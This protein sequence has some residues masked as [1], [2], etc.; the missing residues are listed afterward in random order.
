M[1]YLAHACSILMEYPKN[2]P[3]AT[4]LA[5]S[6]YPNS[7]RASF[8]T[9][10]A[11]PGYQTRQ[12]FTQICIWGPAS[13][14]TAIANGQRRNVM[15]LGKKIAL[16]IFFTVTLISPILLFPVDYY[17]KRIKSDEAKEIKAEESQLRFVPSLQEMAT[18]KAVDSLVSSIEE[19]A[20]D[21][22]EIEVMGT[23]YPE[24]IK[25]DFRRIFFRDYPRLIQEAQQEPLR[26]INV[27]GINRKKV[28]FFRGKI[29]WGEKNKLYSHDIRKSRTEELD[30]QY[31]VNSRFSLYFH[32]NCFYYHSGNENTEETKI[33]KY[34]PERK[35]VDIKF[36]IPQGKKVKYFELINPSGC[37]VACRNNNRQASTLVLNPE[38]VVREFPGK[39]IFT[40]E[41]SERYACLG[42]FLDEPKEVN[43]YCV[44]I[45][46]GELWGPFRS[47]NDRF[48]GNDIRARIIDEEKI[49]T[50]FNNACSISD[51]KTQK[52]LKHITFDYPIL[53]MRIHDSGKE[54]I[55]LNS[56]DNKKTLVHCDLA[57]GTYTQI[58][59]DADIAS[60]YFNP[61][62]GSSRVYTDRGIYSGANRLVTFSGGLKWR[63]ATDGLHVVHDENGK[64]YYSMQLYSS[65]NEAP[66]EDILMLLV[67][68]QQKKS[69][70]AVQPEVIAALE[71]S[72]SE[73]IREIAQRYV[74]KI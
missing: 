34:D 43:L 47:G 19:R 39:Y 30:T 72:S 8:G 25:N 68:L 26:P 64:K 10:I 55:T 63:T 56:G 51:I 59:A 46:T 42:N 70:P 61:S 50:V 40:V 62:A 9:R 24:S 21:L 69:L 12:A 53:K 66:I 6:F 44:E 33:C 74:A 48:W 5:Q 73:R 36:K 28:T 57:I 23:Y 65:L 58:F 7:A 60:N 31:M 41:G 1:K 17:A 14:G 4:C 2:G 22:A 32:E 35:T 37:V 45:T 15:R 16:K 18:E 71:R 49:V 52:L 29:W 38:T 67:A 20:L 54:M 11:Y 13:T 3:Q 27:D